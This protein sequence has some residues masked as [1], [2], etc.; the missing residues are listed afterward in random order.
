MCLSSFVVK[1]IMTMK[2]LT[3]L[4]PDGQSSLSTAASIIGAYEIFARANEYWTDIGKSEL[5]KI[6]LAGISTKSEIYSGMVTVKPHTHISSIS[7]TNLII[8]PSTLI[9]TYES[10]LKGKKQL[11]DW[12]TKQYKE[13][14][15]I[16]S[17]CTGAFMLA[18][19]GLLDGR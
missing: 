15:E 12:I 1:K 19:A 9:R 13:G 3:I 8:I 2:H 6:Q 18:S 17:I 7:K 14:A 10:A 4:V 16:A 11:I 5:F